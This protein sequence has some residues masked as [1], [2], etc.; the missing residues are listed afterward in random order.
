[1]SLLELKEQKTMDTLHY[2]LPV[3][4]LQSSNMNNP[5][6]KRPKFKLEPLKVL[7]PSNKKLSLPEAQRI[8]YIVEELIR[9]LEIVEYLP[10]IIN[11]VD[12]VQNVLSTSLT[13]EE[14]KRNYEQ[15]FISMCHHHKALLDSYTHGQYGQNSQTGQT[16]ESIEHLIKSSCKD[17]LRAFQLKPALFEKFKKEFDSNFKSQKS[18]NK[19][20]ISKF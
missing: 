9:K 5:N 2:K 17:L 8:V 6:A 7:E 3:G 14:R 20:L 18:N 4:T 10:F 11:N 1:M 19:E 15:I 13:D 16:R 12:K